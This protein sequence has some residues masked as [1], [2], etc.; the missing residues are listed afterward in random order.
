MSFTQN[1]QRM[2]VQ[3]AK[4]ILVSSGRSI[5]DIAEYLGYHDVVSFRRVFKKYTGVLPGEYREAERQ[6]ADGSG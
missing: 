3:H 2:K 4:K 6:G 1:I 5:A